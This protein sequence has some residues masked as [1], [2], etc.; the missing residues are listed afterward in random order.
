MKKKR[1]YMYKES[2]CRLQLIVETTALVAVDVV[3]V[4]LG[5]PELTRNDNRGGGPLGDGV[6]GAAV[7]G[8]GVGNS[9]GVDDES[10][11]VQVVDIITNLVVVD[12]V[13]LASL[14]AEEL[15]LRLSLLALGTG[16]ETTSGNADLQERSVVGTASEGSRGR[17][18]LLGLEEILELLLDGIGASRAGKVVGGSVT[19]VDEETVV[20][21]GNHIVVEV[22]ADLVEGLSASIGNPVLGS[23]KTE[24]LWINVSIRS[25]DIYERMPTSSPER[26]ADS[27]LGRVLSEVLG[28]LELSNDTR[29]VIVDTRATSNRVR[30]S[31]ELNNV[32]LVTATGGSENVGG[33]PVLGNGDNV[34]VSDGGGT[35]GNLGPEL[36]GVLESDTGEGNVGALS[37]FG[38]A[39]R[40]GVHGLAGDVVVEEDGGGTGGT[41]EGV[42]ETELASSTADESNLASDL[43]R[44]VGLCNG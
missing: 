18:R 29:A 41:T 19:V 22:E 38:R 2:K 34:D 42:L 25:I 31:T 30:M 5:G 40:T 8:N 15:G 14:A 35:S 43:G 26:E 10:L 4:G 3:N 17:G 36:V 13:S 12:I 44:V 39:E 32:V 9:L 16:E 27:V 21:R 1:N 23:N 33:G 28:N 6:G 20:G 37:T 24:L 11:P 7:E